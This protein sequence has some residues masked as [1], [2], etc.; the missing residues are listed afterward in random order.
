[1]KIAQKQELDLEKKVSQNCLHCNKES[2][3]C[4]F[5]LFERHYWEIVE[6]CKP[7]S[8]PSISL[9]L[10]FVSGVKVFFLILLLLLPL[11]YILK[12]SFCCKVRDHKLVL[13][14]PSSPFG[15]GAKQDSAWKGKASESDSEFHKGHIRGCKEEP[16]SSPISAPELL[17]HISLKRLNILSHRSFRFI[18]VLPLAMP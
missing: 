14:D 16:E 1:M 2:F 12:N 8:T 6:K 9:S 7:T 15:Y 13:Y 4:W 18:A 3:K 5:S 11:I 17:S 10:L